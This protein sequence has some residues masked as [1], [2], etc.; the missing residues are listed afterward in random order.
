MKVILKDKHQLPTVVQW[1]KW[2]LLSTVQFHQSGE[3]EGG[4]PRKEGKQ[5]VQGWAGQRTGEKMYSEKG[6][7]K[8]LGDNCTY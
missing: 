2:H 6:G 1:R 8:L 7:K 4:K 3:R 5:L